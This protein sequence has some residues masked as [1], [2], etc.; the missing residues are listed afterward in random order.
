[1][2]A[3]NTKKDAKNTDETLLA[4]AKQE[5]PKGRQNAFEQILLKYEKLIY[6]V[7]R[8]YFN[9][10]EDAKDASQDAAVK[11]YNGLARVI[12]PEGGNLKAW[13]CTITARTCLDSLR[14]RRPQTTEY[15]EEIVKS[16]LPSAEDMASANERVQEILAAIKKLPEDQRMVLIL[17]DMQGLSYDELAD[18]LQINVGTVKSRLSRA[19]AG[20][21]KILDK[22]V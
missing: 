16:T 17:R 21:K 10:P 13:I 18:A 1:M 19:R 3:M 9:N 4:L 7:A 5:I 6:Y 12:L 2:Q 15:T 20:L 8:R 11:I 22:E 14:K